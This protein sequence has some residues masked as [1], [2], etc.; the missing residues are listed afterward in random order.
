MI[1]KKR[2]VTG[3]SD[4]GIDFFSIFF[5]FTFLLVI[6]GFISIPISGYFK[7]VSL[8]KA[9][10][11][12]CNSNYTLLDVALNGDEITKLCQIKNQTLT[13]K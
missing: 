2:S 3:M 1:N 8:Q 11:Q 9:L 6:L 7:T 12:E 10:N 5:G 4:Y 13:I